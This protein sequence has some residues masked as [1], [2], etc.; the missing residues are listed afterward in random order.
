MLNA[1]EQRIINRYNNVSMLSRFSG[2]I[3]A[4]KDTDV[5]AA[6]NL[7]FADYAQGTRFT[8][9]TAFYI[10]S[11]SKMF[12]AACILLLKEQ[13][14]LKL[15][16][17]VGEYFSD[18]KKGG[19]VTVKQL[20]GHVSG[21]LNFTA[22]Q[23]FWDLGDKIQSPDDIYEFIKD[24][25]LEWETG[26]RFGYSNTNYILL[27]LIIE[28]LS[29]KRYGDFLEEYIFT[30]L[31]MTHSGYTPKSR[32]ADILNMAI[33][34][35]TLCPQPAAAEKVNP[36]IPFAAGGI[37]SCVNDLL[38]WS[39]DLFNGKVLAK[40][41]LQEMI[42]AD[43]GDYGLGIG[44]KKLEIGGKNYT[45]AEHSGFIPGFGSKFARILE[46]RHTF[47]LLCNVA[48]AAADTEC[49]SEVMD[50]INAGA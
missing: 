26:S 29:G 33:G 38:K 6:L 35:D 42:T 22:S 7:G 40:E 37:H 14:K 50:C 36:A 21:I 41:S 11:L 13:G 45:M 3:L 10:A 17:S 24:M 1:L 44:I 49:F 9:D 8:G 2:C 4:A 20:L 43:R 47:I 25:D 48:D 5:L 39:I 27:G 18:Y 34:Y 28:K 15:T 16:D 46:T 31:N 23:A 12:T 30:P 19:H 32:C